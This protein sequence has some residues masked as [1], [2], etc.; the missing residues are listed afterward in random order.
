MEKTYFKNSDHSFFLF[1]FPEFES[2][3][4]CCHTCKHVLFAVQF[5]HPSGVSR[6]CA[7]CAM[8]VLC[9][10]GNSHSTLW[11]QFSVSQPTCA[12]KHRTYPLSKLV[13]KID[14]TWE[15]SGS[16]WPIEACENLWLVPDPFMQIC[17]RR[18]WTT[19]FW[20]RS[21]RSLTRKL[22][23]PMVM[24]RLIPNSCEMSW[25]RVEMIDA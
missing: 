15:T 11:T 5:W 20:T 12:C 19:P 21:R 22:K 13:D 10:C 3:M 25:V 14:R 1:S 8:V 6:V 9:K 2:K 4:P 23:M 18:L 24:K 16:V 7:A 17:L